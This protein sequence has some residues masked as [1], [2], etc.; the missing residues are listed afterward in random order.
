MSRH[1]V[2]GG[3]CFLSRIRCIAGVV[4]LHLYAL[5]VGGGS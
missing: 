2:L 1:S 3:T 4:W 5:S